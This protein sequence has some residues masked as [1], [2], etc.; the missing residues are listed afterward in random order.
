MT[1]KTP[2]EDGNA[3]AAL[4]ATFARD[5]SVAVITLREHGIR[6]PNLDDLAECVLA[7]RE[8]VL[9]AA[10]ARTRE[11]RQPDPDYHYDTMERG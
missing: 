6:R 11:A 10:Q 3:I 8:D 7:W 2:Q 5:M 9:D 1:Y 4:M